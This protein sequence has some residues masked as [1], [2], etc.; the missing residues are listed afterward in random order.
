MSESTEPSESIDANQWL[1]YW[2]RAMPPG[3]RL[4]RSGTEPQ[5][6][7]VDAPARTDR[8]DGRRVERGRGSTPDEA[9]RLAYVDTTQRLR[10]DRE[11]G[12]P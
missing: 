8:P 12:S 4:T 10:R 5:T 11:R 9:I 2:L 1:G 3:F 7:I 6:W